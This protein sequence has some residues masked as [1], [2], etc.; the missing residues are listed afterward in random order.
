M[1]RPTPEFPAP[2]QYLAGAATSAASPRP[3]A[4]TLTLVEALRATADRLAKG[5]VRFRWTHMGACNCGHLTQT[6]TSLSAADIHALALQKAGDWGE[7]AREYCPTSGYPIDHII[8]RL[9]ALGLSTE[10]L[11]HLERLDD[12]RV[13]RQLPL[14]ERHLDCRRRDDVVRYLR[15]WADLVDARAPARLELETVD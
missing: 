10:D 6:V 11:Y 1:G 3:P 14:G 12:P 2:P 4:A 5:D 8:D 7:Q 13:L 15:A 9:L